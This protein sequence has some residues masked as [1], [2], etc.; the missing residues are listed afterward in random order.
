[1]QVQAQ[2]LQQYKYQSTLPSPNLRNCLLVV[3]QDLY[4]VGSSHSAYKLDEGMDDSQKPYFITLLI[5]S[6][7]F[8]LWTVVISI[9]SHLILSAE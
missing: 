3:S 8:N 5:N 2:I 1:M 7:Q 4:Q 9:T 6:V